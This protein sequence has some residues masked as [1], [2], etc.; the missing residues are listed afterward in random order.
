MLY[1]IVE[2]HR[3]FEGPELKQV[4]V[5]ADSVKQAAAE[6][7][8]FAKSNAESYK[9]I[10]HA[11]CTQ[12]PIGRAAYN[13]P[14]S[15]KMTAEQLADW[16]KNYTRYPKDGNATPPPFTEISVGKVIE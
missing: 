14:Y 12:A 16:V 10:S 1:A 11:Y 8:L 6:W 9:A 5:S 2:V 7:R 3:R 4:L 13:E 15:A